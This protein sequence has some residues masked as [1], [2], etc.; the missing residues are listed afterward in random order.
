MRMQCIQFLKIR[1]LKE[2]G[3]LRV[4]GR[5]DLIQQMKDAFD[6]G[7][8]SPSQFMT[9]P[10]S[11]A[12]KKKIFSAVCVR[13]RGI[14][15]CVHTF[16]MHVGTHIH[17]VRC[18]CPAEFSFPLTVSLTISARLFARWILDVD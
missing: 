12:G 4:P 2:E 11:V 14:Q 15:D 1:G 8:T 7:V 18:S 6:A 16:R 5:N 10:H 13:V 3:L 9:D 17:V